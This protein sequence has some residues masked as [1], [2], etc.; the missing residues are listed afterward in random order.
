LQPTSP[1]SPRSPR[2]ASISPNP[3][4]DLYTTSHFSSNEGKYERNAPPRVSLRTTSYTKSTGHLNHS[5]DHSPTDYH[6]L[7]TSLGKAKSELYVNDEYAE[8]P[9]RLEVGHVKNLSKLFRWVSV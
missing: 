1:L 6:N 2:S 8:V 9:P 7:R 3:R 4:G 5:S